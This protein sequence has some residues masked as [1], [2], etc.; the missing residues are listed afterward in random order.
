MTVNNKMGSMRWA[1]VRNNIKYD[2]VYPSNMVLAG[3]EDN[4]TDLI[5]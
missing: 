2:F 3:H 1:E 5:G 4:M